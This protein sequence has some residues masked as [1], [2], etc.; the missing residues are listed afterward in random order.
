MPR[1]AAITLTPIEQ[2]LELVRRESETIHPEHPSQGTLAAILASFA[3]HFSQT[4]WEEHRQAGFPTEKP[5]SVVRNRIAYEKA[6]QGLRAGFARGGPATHDYVNGRAEA[7]DNGIAHDLANHLENLLGMN[8]P[9][10]IEKT[11]QRVHGL[12]G[13]SYHSDAI[14]RT[15]H[16]LGKEV[17][18]EEFYHNTSNRRKMLERLK[19][20]QKAALRMSFPTPLGESITD[21]KKVQKAIDDMVEKF[22]Y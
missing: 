22:N 3:K 8:P 15:A 10:E 12:L 1:R 21:Q 13:A 9:M 11:G 6:L 7:G 17:Y 16:N 20:I 4:A 14:A 2:A 19:K 18:R 5:A